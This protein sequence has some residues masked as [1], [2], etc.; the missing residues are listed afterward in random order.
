MCPSVY[1]VAYCG[2]SRNCVPQN[3]RTPQYFCAFKT[4]QKL[5]TRKKELSLNMSIQ[6][7]LDEVKALQKRVTELEDINEIRHLQY[8]YGYYLDKCVYSV[9]ALT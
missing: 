9:G 1:A 8:K 5:P 7:V 6:E 3:C 4:R 2:N